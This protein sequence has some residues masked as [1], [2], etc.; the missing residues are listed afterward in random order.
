MVRTRKED[1]RI[2]TAADNSRMGTR[3][4]T[5]KRKAPKKDGWMDREGRNVIYNRLTEE[6]TMDRV[7]WRN[8]VLGERNPLYSGQIHECVNTLSLPL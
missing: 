2:Q 8:L 1:V 5:K 4:N 3:G 7:M 6:D